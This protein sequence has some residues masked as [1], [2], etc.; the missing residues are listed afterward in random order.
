VSDF[1][2][3]LVVE[4]ARPETLLAAAR[5]IRD[6]YA[7]FAAHAREAGARLDPKQAWAPVVAAFR[8]GLERA[9]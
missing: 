8:R 6:N 4:D 9:R 3:G 7:A 5:T 2:A 1:G